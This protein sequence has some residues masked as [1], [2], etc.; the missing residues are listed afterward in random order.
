MQSEDDEDSAE[1]DGMDIDDGVSA[2]PTTG[3]KTSGFDWTGDSFG[4]TVNGAASDSEPEASATKKKRRHKPEIKVDMTGDLDKYG[5]RSVSDF[6]RQLLGQPNNSALWVQY[7]AFHLEQNELQKVRDIAERALRTIHIR[8]LEEKSKIWI[9]WL[10]LEVEYSDEETVEEVFKRACQVQD[11]VDMHEHLAAIY[12]NAKKQD[13]AN[14]VFERMVANKEFRA[15]PALWLNYATFLLNNFNDAA[16]AR[17][18][19]SR[20]LQSVPTNEHRLLT[21][22]FASLEFHSKH[23]DPERG[24]TIFEGLFSEWPKWSS[25]WDMWVDLEQ[26]RLSHVATKGSKEQKEERKEGREKVR[27]LYERMA[28]QKMKKR[29]AKFV[30]KRWLEFEEKEGDAKGV[31]R[32]KGLAREFV[33]GMKGDE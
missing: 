14:A 2:K 16:R 27:A 18:M 30:F 13:K 24:R 21:A 32:V 11:P 31:E 19:L 22:K 4:A 1:V 33:E 3:L 20:S 23:G 9:A 7:M 26:A 15:S 10:N 25:G 29:R 5:P 8:E 28:G 6:E 12:I 17:S